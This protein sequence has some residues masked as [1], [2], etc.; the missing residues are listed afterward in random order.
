MGIGKNGW[1]ESALSQRGG[2]QHRAGSDTEEGCNPSSGKT[3]MP[4]GGVA[5]QR[6]GPHNGTPAR[7]GGDLGNLQLAVGGDAAEHRGY[8]SHGIDG[9]CRRLDGGGSDDRGDE[10]TAA[11]NAFI[12]GPGLPPP[13]QATQALPDTVTTP[14]PA[15]VEIRCRLGER[16]RDEGAIRPPGAP[17]G[18]R[19][20]AQD[21]IGVLPGAG[22]V[23]K[24][25]GM[26]GPRILIESVEV[27]PDAGS[28]GIEMDV[29]HEFE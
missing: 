3:R 25:G 9:A 8:K 4:H 14:Q 21:E 19:K 7:G 18:G 1:W 20:L 13:C 16:I 23:T 6:A 5:D 17:D 24:Q 10:V 2:L 26:A 28:Q 11:E 29:A 22:M 15:A 12:E 27:A